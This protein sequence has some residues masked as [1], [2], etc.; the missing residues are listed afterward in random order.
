[1]GY[2]FHS[3]SSI[4]SC[5]DASQFAFGCTS[6]EKDATGWVTFTFLIGCVAGALI[7][8][9]LADS[10]G[11]KWS[12]LLGCIFFC[13]GGLLQF[14]T[15]SVPMFYSGRVASGVGVGIMSMVVPLYISETAPTEKR[16]QMT[17]INQLMITSGVL[18][19]A[20]VN[21]AIIASRGEQDSITWRLCLAM[22]LIPAV[23]LIIVIF[24]MP[25]SPRWLANK[26]RDAEAIAVLTRLRGIDE[27]NN[28]L[29]IE[30]NDIKSA[31]RKERATGQATYVELLTRG[32]INRVLIAILLQL[33]QQFTG[34]NGV[35]YFQ[36]VLYQRLGFGTTAQQV[37]T[38]ALDLINVLGTLPS[39]FLV[40]RV[41][42]K[43][44]VGSWWN[45]HRCF[46]RHDMHLHHSVGKKPEDGLRSFCV[47]CVVR[48]VLCI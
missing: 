34:I 33:F 14:L 36:T 26:D 5:K 6:F 3:N 44:T 18:L 30:F 9:S 4:E 19:A 7:V 20:L 37:L 21:A 45:R 27:F 12:I 31:I 28:V 23:L 2:R 25:N 40:D 1:M 24:F 32:I 16:G 35:L 15:T 11:R 41:G 22:Q 10:M 38:V 13:I 17:A 39:M 42:R 47:H 46:T 29:Q 48:L 43:K 8:S